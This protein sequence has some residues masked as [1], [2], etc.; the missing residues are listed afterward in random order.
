MISNV[1]PHPVSGWIASWVVDHVVIVARRYDPFD[2]PSLLT[3]DRA[4]AVAVKR[5][6]GPLEKI[7]IR[8]RLDCGTSRELEWGTR[9]DVRRVEA[10]CCSGAPRRGEKERVSCP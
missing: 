10:E 2:E 5:I 8:V 7:R 4:A 9:P 3:E 1:P 6:R